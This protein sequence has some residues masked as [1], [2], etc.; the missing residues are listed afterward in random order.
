LLQGDLENIFVP[1]KI[2]LSISPVAMHFLP[3]NRNGT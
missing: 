1:A 3:D 2:I